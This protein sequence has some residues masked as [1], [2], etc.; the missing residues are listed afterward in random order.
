M[1]VRFWDFGGRK[2]WMWNLGVSKLGG[3]ESDW[4]ILED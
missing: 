3:D 4:E 2:F 1:E